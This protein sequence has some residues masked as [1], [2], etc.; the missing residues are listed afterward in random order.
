MPFTY[1]RENVLL[2]QNESVRRILTPVLQEKRNISLKQDMFSMRMYV[3]M[4]V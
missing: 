2:K 1:V 3:F 4:Y